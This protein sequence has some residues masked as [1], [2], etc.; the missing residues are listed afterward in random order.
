M[1]K[2]NIVVGPIRK[3]TNFLSEDIFR[4]NLYIGK[5]YVGS[6]KTKFNQFNSEK[7]IEEAVLL[8]TSLGYIN[9]SSINNDLELF[10]NFILGKVKL[11]RRVP[12]KSLQLFVDEEELKPFNVKTKRKFK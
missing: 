11:I 3:C 8:K 10:K 12:R 5:L 7:Y 9:I 2:E 1:K 6:L 4:T